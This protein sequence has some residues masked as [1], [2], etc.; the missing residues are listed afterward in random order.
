GPAP[1]RGSRR[2][3]ERDGPRADRPLRVRLRHD[4][5]PGRGHRTTTTTPTAATAAHEPVPA[6]PGPL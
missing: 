5:A 1:R 6:E 3:R 4:G 2:R